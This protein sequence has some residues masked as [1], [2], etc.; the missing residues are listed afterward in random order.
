MANLDKI[1]ELQHLHQRKEIRQGI[2]KAQI[3][4]SLSYDEKGLVNMKN[5]PIQWDVQP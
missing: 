1:S 5:V 2:Q 3:A 4:I